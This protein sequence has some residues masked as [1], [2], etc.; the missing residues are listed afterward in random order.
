MCA[1]L[2]AA[3]ICLLF[4]CSLSSAVAHPPARGCIMLVPAGTTLVTGEELI[5]SDL[6]IPDAQPVSYLSVWGT[7]TWTGKVVQPY[8]RV[9]MTPKPGDGAATVSVRTPNSMYWVKIS[10]IQENRNL[11]VCQWSCPM[12]KPFAGAFEHIE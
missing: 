6:C 7:R 1:P 10:P 5:R 2:M 4:V 3:V 9:T 11:S 8:N 12:H